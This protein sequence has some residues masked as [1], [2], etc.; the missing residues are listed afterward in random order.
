[1]S[2][3]LSGG[4]RTHCQSL[5]G[6]KAVLS[7]GTWTQQLGL[8]MPRPHP[9]PHPTPTPPPNG[10]GSHRPDYC[11]GQVGQPRLLPDPRYL[12]GRCPAHVQQCQGVDLQDWWSL[13]A[14]CPDGPR[15]G[16]GGVRQTHAAKPLDCLLPGVAPLLLWHGKPSIG[17]PGQTM[18]SRTGLQCCRHH[19]PQDRR[20]SEQ[21]FPAMGGEQRGVDR[22][23][24]SGSV[25]SGRANALG[26]STLVRDWPMKRG[27]GACPTAACSPEPWSGTLL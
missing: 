25:Q 3:C 17:Y 22:L 19:L 18:L 8:P 12:R 26:H 14:C 15:E 4:R 27:A 5:L 16:G 9:H 21:R 10:S 11:P 2:V 20:A 13:S 6:N 1:M 23:R 7:H 24:A